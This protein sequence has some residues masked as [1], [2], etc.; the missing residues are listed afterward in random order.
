MNART[1]L[2]FVMIL[3]VSMI[4]S[5]LLANLRRGRNLYQ[6]LAFI[7]VVVSL[8]AVSLLFR[9]LLDP[10]V[11]FVNTFLKS[12]GLPTSKWLTSSDTALPT[13]SLIGA[14]KGIGFYIVIL[15]AGLMGIPE[16]MYD[17]AKVDGA[18]EW[19]RFWNVTIPLL[20][21][22][23]LLMSVLLAIGA[24]QEFG[25]PYVMTGGGP[26]NATYLYNLYIYNAAFQQM[27]F[28]TA[29]A[30]ALLQFVVIMVVSIMQIRLLRPKWSY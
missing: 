19:Q 27:R 20:S 7:P 22:T 11:G 12:V 18:N 3:P 23:L 6:A 9:M 8:V 25:L 5:V 24:L 13:T 21:N 29:T 16:E 26:S 30:A 4:L 10:S 17:A 2:M 1:A 14:W 28:G 15:T